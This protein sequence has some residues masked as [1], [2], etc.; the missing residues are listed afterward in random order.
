MLTDS[1]QHMF[2]A[3]EPAMCQAQCFCAPRAALG[4]VQGWRGAKCSGGGGRRG[5]RTLAG[6]Q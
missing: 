4:Q 2:G 3:A 6:A 1:A 5:V